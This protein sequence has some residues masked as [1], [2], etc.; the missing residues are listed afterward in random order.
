MAFKPATLG[1]L[2]R[3]FAANRYH[4]TPAF[5]YPYKDSQDRESL[6][7]RSSQNTKSGRD[8]DVAATPKAAFGRDVTSPEGERATATEEEG[9]D[10]LEVSGANQ[11]LSKPQGDERAGHNMGA[12]KEVRK[13]GRSGGGGAPKK[14]DASKLY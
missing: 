5:A 3:L 12:G 7:P 11:A 8:D 13:G 9:S 10:P 14:G 2:P 1:A 4:T 6:K